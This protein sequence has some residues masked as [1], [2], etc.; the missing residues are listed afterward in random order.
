MTAPSACGGVQSNH[1][2]VTAA[3][4][5]KLGL[6]CILVANGRAPDRLT[7]NALLD[8]LLGAEVRYVGDR[9]DRA[10]AMDA[11]ADEVRRAGGTPYVIPYRLRIDWLEIIA[12]F[13]GGQKWPTYL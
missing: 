6:R 12:V 5:A 2:R 13:H 11:G 9:A 10:P 1:A 4:A 7:A 8:R 3:A